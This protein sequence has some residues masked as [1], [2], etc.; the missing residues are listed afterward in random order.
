MGDVEAEV[1][2][3]HLTDPS[4]GGLRARGGRRSLCESLR[5]SVGPVEK[6]DFL[7]V[8]VVGDPTGLVALDGIDLTYSTGLQYGTPGDRGGDRGRRRGPAFGVTA[9]WSRRG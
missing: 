4:G 9:V 5:A 3:C 2:A 6:G 1:A 7:V 8:E